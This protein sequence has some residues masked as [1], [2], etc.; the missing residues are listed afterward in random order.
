MQD[1]VKLRPVV[2]DVD[3]IVYA[4]TSLSAYRPQVPFEVKVSGPVSVCQNLKLLNGIFGSSRKSKFERCIKTVQYGLFVLL[5]IIDYRHMEFTLGGDPALPIRVLFSNKV[6]RMDADP[7]D[8]SSSEEPGEMITEYNYRERFFHLVFGPAVDRLRR[9]SISKL[10][11]A[12]DPRSKTWHL[13]PSDWAKVSFEVNSRM[14]ELEIF[15]TH[16]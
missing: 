11:G 3:S 14:E 12:G 8:S 13:H 1:Q 5:L 4:F 16:L 9:S 2:V 15:G 6:N 10:K 7:S